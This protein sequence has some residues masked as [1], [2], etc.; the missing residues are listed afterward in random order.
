MKTILL[1]LSVFV[2]AC[3]N[4]APCPDRKI[5]LFNS[6]ADVGGEKKCNVTLDNQAKIEVMNP[7]LGD[8]VSSCAKPEVKTVTAE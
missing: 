7:K 2:G 6:C 5:I 8:V 1:A 4:N 3:Q